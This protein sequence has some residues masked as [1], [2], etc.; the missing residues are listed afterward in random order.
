MKINAIGSKLT[1]QGAFGEVSGV[2]MSEREADV[3]LSVCRAQQLAEQ[4]SVEN[5]HS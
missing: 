5:S 4:G 3:G 1:L 2:I